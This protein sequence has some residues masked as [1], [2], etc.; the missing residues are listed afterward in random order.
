MDPHRPQT[1]SEVA[2]EENRRL[3]HTIRDLVA[4]AALPAVWIGLD[5]R[6]MARSLADVL[7]SALS[8]DLIY[9]RLDGHS[10]EDPVEVFR[11]KHRSAGACLEAVRESLLPFID[12]DRAEAP[13]TIPDPFGAGKLHIAVTRFGSGDSHGLVISGSRKRGF[14]TEEDRVLLGVG[15]NQ[16]AIVEQRR[17]SEEQLRESDA[18]TRAILETA[19]DCVI[20]MDYSGKVVEFNPAAEKIFGYRRAEVIGRELAECIIPAPLRARH[21]RSLAN[22]LAT[23]QT[24]I[25]GRRIELTALRADGTEFPVELA[26][27]RIS[28]DG[29]ALFSAHLRDLSERVRSERRRNVRLLV[30]QVL[31]K[32][33]AIS[34]AASNVLQAICEGLGWEAGFLWKLEADTGALHCLGGWHAPG[35]ELSRFDAASRERT[36]RRGEGLPGEAWARGE[37]VW[38]PDV[39]D[40]QNFLRATAAAEEGLHAALSWPLLAGRETMGVIEL[41]SD[42]I[43]E[44]DADLLET[45]A[46]VAGQV[47]QFMERKKAEEV[48]RQSEVRFRGLMEQAPF[49]IQ[50]FAPD[51]RTVQVNRAWQELWGISFEEGLAYNILEDRQLE[52]KGVLQYVRRGFAGQATAIPAIQ[53]NPNDTLPGATRYADPR[54]WLSAVIYPLKDSGGQVREVVLVHEDITVRKRLEEELHARVKDLADADR[55][56]DE[57]LATLAHELRNPLAPIRNSLQIL[58]M[59]MV[60]A[61]TAQR[62]REVMERQVHHL[63]RLV[64]DLLDVSRAM[65]GKIELRKESVELATVIARAVE[66]AQPLIEVQEHDLRIELPPGSMLMNADPVRLSQVV[67]NLLTNAAKYTEPGGRISLSVRRE[68]N[69]ALLRVTDDGIGIAPDVLPHIFELFVQVDHATTRSQGGLG[70]GLTLVKKLVEMHGGTVEAHSKGLGEGSE[71]AVHLPLLVREQLAPGE[72]EKD[73]RRP[74]AV[75]SGYRLLVVDD[76]EDAAATLATLLRLQ[77]HQVRVAHDGVSALGAVK[78]DRPALILLDLGMP[79]MDGYEVARRIREIPEV[80]NTLLAALTGWGQQEDR[81]RTTEAGFDYH[82][83][84]PLQPA[85]LEALMADLKSTQGEQ[86]DP[87]AEGLIE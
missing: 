81:R 29:P 20:A 83:V 60:D 12:R 67:A 86:C 38:L 45:M 64:D 16:T 69:E 78:A 49:S 42:R 50:M 73:E 39:D 82:L 2:R 58:K 10:D 36:F 85:V 1:E 66:T 7:L 74:V 34:E 62:T 13:A 71:F 75:S 68:G 22:H 57:F 44:P 52:A 27:T 48:L 23:G 76:N 8:L 61:T 51:G 40:A 53:Y 9:F 77:G 54:R 46:T 72:E 30:P 24:N 70:I 21:R 4:L 19:L 33:A 32:A 17:R 6:G 41:F 5:R 15:A 18:Q 11:S 59:P 26:I 87:S 14:P 55:R 43:R 63:V 31:A 47:G 56:K 28:R 37:P 79:G 3:R 80:K 25:L 35:L 84:K 65:R